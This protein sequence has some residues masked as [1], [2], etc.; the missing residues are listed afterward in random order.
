MIG[1]FT[2]H[3]TYLHG[4]HMLFTGYPLQCPAYFITK[5]V[6]LFIYVEDITK[7]C[8]DMNFIFEW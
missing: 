7:L 8:E 1:Q 5:L 2:H 3:T 6:E 4:S